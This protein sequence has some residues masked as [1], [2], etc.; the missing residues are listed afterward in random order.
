MDILADAHHTQSKLLSPITIIQPPEPP[1]PFL[2][3]EEATTSSPCINYTRPPDLLLPMPTVSHDLPT[4]QQGTMQATARIMK[5]RWTLHHTATPHVR[6][7]VDGGAN[8]SITNDREA[9]L[10]YK[11]I[12]KYP[13]SGVAAGEPALVCTGMGYL[14]WQADDT[15]VVL[16]KCYY[17]SDAA[18]TIVSPTDIVINNFSDFK[19]WSQHSD[20]ETKKGYIEFHHRHVQPS[21]K[22]T[23]TM[24]NGLW[25]YANN[26]DATDYATDKPHIRRLTK[27]LEYQ[28][29]HY[30][31]G[32]MGQRH[33]SGIHHHVDH[34][35]KLHIPPLFR[36]L[37]CMM[38][39]GD[40]RDTTSPDDEHRMAKFDDWFQ[41]D[42]AVLQSDDCTPGQHFH[43][44]FGFM[45]GSGYSK[46]DEDGQIITSID[47]Y[48]A[49]FIII[50]RKTRYLWIFLTKNKK[51]PIKIFQQFLREHGNP[52]AHNRTVR[53]DK[54]KELWGSDAFKQVVQDAGYIMEPTAPDAPFQNGRVENPNGTLAKTVRCL[55][56]NAGLGPEFW[57]FALLHAVYLKN[58]KPHSATNQVPLTAYSGQRPNAKR[59]KIFGC[60][61]IVRNLG[62]RPY[63]LDLHTSAG[64]F[65]GYCATDK[66]IVYLD[67]VTNRFK[68]ATHVVFDEAGMT[69]P[70]AALYPAAKVLQDLGYGTDNIEETQGETDHGTLIEAPNDANPDAPPVDAGSHVPLNIT[71]SVVDARDDGD[72]HDNPISPMPLKVKFLS[73]NATMPTRATDGSVGYDLFSAVDVVIQSNKRCCVPL[74]LSIIPPPGTYAQIFSRSGLSLKSNVDV[75]A[76][77]IDPDYTGNI[78]VLLEN[79][80]DDP[81]TIRIGDRIAQLVLLQIQTPAVSEISVNATLPETVRGT[82]GFGSTG[83]G[84]AMIRNNTAI[85]DPSAE[86]RESSP[87]IQD[88]IIERPFNLYFS[89]DPFD[90]IMEVDVAIKGDHETLGILTD[91]CDCRQRLQIK[92]MALS[93]PGSRLKKWRSVL[94]HTYILKFND[95][96]IQSHEDFAHA[97][98][99]TRL[100]KMMKAKLIVATDTAYGLHPMEGVLQIHFDQMN[101]ISKHLQDIARERD[102][103]TIN[104]LPTPTTTTVR[105]LHDHCVVTE[106]ADDHPGP[107]PPPDP[108][109]PPTLKAEPELAQSFTKKQLLK[110]DDWPDWERSQ[111]KQLDQYWEQGM[112]SSPLPLPHNANALHMLWRFNLKVCGTKKSRMVCNGSPHQKGTVT[113]GHTYANAL[114]AASERLFWAIVANQNYIAVG[115]DVSNAFAEAPAPKAPLY[116]YIDDTFRQWWTKHKGNEPIPADCN[117]VRVH[118]AIQGHPE[119]PRLWEKHIDGILREL[120]LTPATH[121]PC[122]Y[123]GDF[124]GNRVLFLR[125]VDDFAVAAEHRDTA[126][127]LINA[128]NNKMR[129]EVKHLGL[130]DRFNGMDIHQ[131]RHYIKITCEKY[132][133]KMIKS[134][135]NL[136]QHVPSNPV[137][138]PADNNYIKMLETAKVPDTLPEKLKLKEDMGFNY[139]QLIGEI[140][141]PMMK[142][143]P[144][145]APHGI[146]LSQ[147]MENPAKEHYYAIRDILGY[148]S[149]TITE[150]IYYWRKTPRMDL[151]EMEL[152]IPHQDN[153]FMEDNTPSGGDLYGYTDSDWGTDSVHRKSISG[154]V[155]MYAG[156]VIGYKCKY[157]DVIAHSSTE[158]EFTAACDAGKMILFFRSILEDLGYEQLDATVLYEDNNGA[159]MMANA[160]QPTRRTRHMD[161]KKFALLDWVEQDLIILRSIKT[162]ENAADGLTK[163]LAKQLFHRHTDTILGRRVPDYVKRSNRDIR[164]Q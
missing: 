162:A 159:L 91:Y 63:K 143:R 132:L 61:V 2:A 78:Q 7:H 83:M 87:S 38:A 128:I 120:G 98:R 29:Y 51:P 66:N 116:M 15:S 148:L 54:G 111:Y 18:E 156:G 101:I 50:D 57:S 95:F 10:H 21:V 1:P 154:I 24:N 35:P 140:I 11:N 152:P 69:L 110:R 85:G 43:V 107:H 147:Y 44:D 6:V 22:F 25:Y 97:V 94:R 36:C 124:E 4:P 163:P 89:D 104:S 53:S 55:L 81:F 117:V 134:H 64:T 122:F 28:L 9:L 90:N 37:T 48:R 99:Q 102:L 125:Q 131:T 26:H 133:Q 42:D 158:A 114:D 161:I 17:S 153:Y 72:G 105:Q 103:Q 127:K 126:M 151:P 23:L 115:A 118:N 8:R 32:C 46:R 129:I 73:V 149:K 19:A 121:E 14:P 3:T 138:F 160:Q 113:V 74:D 27:P 65:L 80:G 13:M 146:K 47:G 79:T 34:Q 144:E 52:S 84:T 59:L 20:L 112:F 109:P 155:I 5:N 93:T 76:G 119:S 30:R 39:T 49:Y 100:R 141:F 45:R 70:K 16:V 92:D 68:T 58:R 164:I 33:S 139:R 130:I 31:W 136:L 12:K 75:R 123:S 86:Q 96:A 150:G 82:N 56:Y 135:E 71:T 60:P 142:C 67:N 88:S 41:D 77:T 137:P 108:P 62:K 40:Y 106:I 145:I 157:Q